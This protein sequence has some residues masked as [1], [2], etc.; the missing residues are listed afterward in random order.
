MKN[1]KKIANEI[2]TAKFE[3]E[4]EFSINPFD[5][6][7]VV[8]L[9][10]KEFGKVYMV[11][12]ESDQEGYTWKNGLAIRNVH[13]KVSLYVPHSLLNNKV[14]SKIPKSKKKEPLLN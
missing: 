14:I 10:M 8:N 5:Y 6:K 7:N 3:E 1:L 9:L 2:L 13:D 11:A 12:L 4:T